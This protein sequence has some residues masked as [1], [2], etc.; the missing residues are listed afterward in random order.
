MERLA[1]ER[2]EKNAAYEREKRE[3]EEKHR[4]ALE[5]IKKKGNQLLGQDY[6]GNQGPSA[7]Q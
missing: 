3:K 1:K 6:G 4:K 2:Q 7:A 5:V